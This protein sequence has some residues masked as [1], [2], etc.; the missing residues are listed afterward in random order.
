LKYYVNDARQTYRA[1]LNALSNGR[2]VSSTEVALYF[3]EGKK[4]IL[5]YS[6]Q[7]VNV[8]TNLKEDLDMPL[9]IG[10]QVEIDDTEEAAIGYHV[11]M[12]AHYVVFCQC[13]LSLHG[14]NNV[15]LYSFVTSFRVDKPLQALK[16]GKIRPVA[17]IPLFSVD[18]Q[19]GEVTNR[20]SF[21]SRNFRFI[22]LQRCHVVH[23]SPWF[24]MNFS[25]ECCRKLLFLYVPWPD[26]R[27]HSYPEP[28]HSWHGISPPG[29]ATICINKEI[30][31]Q[32]LNVGMPVA[33]GASDEMHEISD[34]ADDDN[35]DASLDHGD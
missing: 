10:I 14:H 17:H 13:Q 21:E 8:N 7:C 29:Y 25:L 15:T 2:R 18:D 22:A 31:R 1:L 35:V 20:M 23:I 26:G 27:E 6:R 34:D 33:N 24:K 19:T 4:G 32:Q 9:N 12:R 30:H 11:K 28:V 5:K 16:N 3:L